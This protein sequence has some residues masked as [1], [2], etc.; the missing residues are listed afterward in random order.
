Y[1]P[2]EHIIYDLKGTTKI[3][4][5]EE[6]LHVMKEQNLVQEY[7]IAL[8]DILDREGYLSTGLENGLAIPHAKTDSIEKL[9][10][11]FG[12]K[13]DGV[14]FESLDGKPSDL[15]FLVL[16]PKDTSGPHIQALALITRNL[17]DVKTRGQIKSCQSA[18][19][20]AKLFQ[21]FN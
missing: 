7:E 1:L 5:I 15:F 13:K 20:I 8:N 17:K 2:L 12:L 21:G 19:E 9:A 18:E 10:I 3:E 11:V 6:M 4:I 14:H 16:S